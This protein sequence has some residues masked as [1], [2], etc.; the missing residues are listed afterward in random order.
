MS[1]NRES[2]SEELT[3]EKYLKREFHI[4]IPTLLGKRIANPFER[5]MI[6]VSIRFWSCTNWPVPS[7]FLSFRTSGFG[8]KFVTVPGFW[9]RDGLVKSKAFTYPIE[10]LLFV[11]HPLP[12]PLL[13]APH[14]FPIMQCSHIYTKW[15]GLFL[16]PGSHMIC[17]G[18]RPSA[19][20]E[21]QIPH[22]SVS[23]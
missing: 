3:I 14:G 6:L 16:K 13:P 12:S 7:G 20:D 23:I 22:T 17:Y 21:S 15:Y 8:G 4:S 2:N 11:A 1:T 9:S 10:I 5:L 18:R 19:I